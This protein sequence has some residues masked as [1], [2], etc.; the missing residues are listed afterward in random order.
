MLGRVQYRAEMHKEALE[1]FKKTLALAPLE[2]KSGLE[3]AI[4][5]IQEKL[6]PTS[7]ESTVKPVSDSH[8]LVIT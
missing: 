4:E 3:K 7:P 6:K 8:G 2:E 5:K 1:S